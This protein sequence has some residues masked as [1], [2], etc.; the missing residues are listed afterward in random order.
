[1]KCQSLFSGR[2]KN[3]IKMLSVVCPV[4]AGLGLSKLSYLMTDLLCSGPSCSKLMMSLINIS[5]KL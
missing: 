1:M 3:N 5:L 2:N 4:S